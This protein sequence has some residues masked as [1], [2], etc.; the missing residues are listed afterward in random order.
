MA[1]V[2][3]DE[4]GGLVELTGVVQ[5][6]VKSDG[7]QNVSKGDIFTID[8]TLERTTPESEIT[9]ACVLVKIRPNE[10]D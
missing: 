8:L 10:K 1:P 9:G 5:A 7:S 3:R 4:T 6:A 2:E